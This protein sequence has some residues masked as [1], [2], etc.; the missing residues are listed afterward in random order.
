MKTYIREILND[1][2][3]PEAAVPTDLDNQILSD[4]PAERVRQM[5]ELN[6]VSLTTL[7]HHYA[8]E[9]AGRGR[10]GIL[11]I[12]RWAPSAR[13]TGVAARDFLI[14]PAVP[15]RLTPGRS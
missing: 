9:M 6:L 8:K 5:I 13:S 2:K 3:K 7:T 14:R 15:D 12:W 1:L 4:D 11:G 10:V